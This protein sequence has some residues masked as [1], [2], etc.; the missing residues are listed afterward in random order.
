M[1]RPAANQ[2]LHP[3]GAAHRFAR[4]DVRAAAPAG[5]LHRYAAGTLMAHTTTAIAVVVAFALAENLAAYPAEYGKADNSTTRPDL[6]TAKFAALAWIDACWNGDARLAHQ[7]LVDD[8]KQRDFMAGPLK[9]SAALRT[10]E[11]TAVKKFGEAGR[12]VSGYPDGSAK[13]VEAKIKIKED[14]DRATVTMDD[15]LLPLELRRIA[16]NWRVD[17]SKA[18]SDPRPN[19]AAAASNTAAKVAEAVAAEIAAGKFKWP[20]EAK[21]A[22]RERRLAEVEK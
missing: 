4:V 13:A 17:V 2:L 14:G 18:A 6:S 22:F 21:R 1:A 16:G 19:R 5:E 7:V 3:T 9:F 11:S 8:P 20:T 15:V 12:Q 10:L